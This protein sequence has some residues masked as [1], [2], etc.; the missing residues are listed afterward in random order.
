MVRYAPHQTTP[1]D[2]QGHDHH[3][4]PKKSL[5]FPRPRLEA[6]VSSRVFSTN[7]A[8]PGPAAG[9]AA[10]RG[11]SRRG[12][13]KAPRTCGLAEGIR[14]KRR[15]EGWDPEEWWHGWNYVKVMTGW[16]FG[17]FFIFPYIEGLKP[18]TRWQ[19]F[20]WN[21]WTVLG[22]IDEVYSELVGN[23][24]VWKLDMMSGS[25][26]IVA[27]I[28]NEDLERFHWSIKSIKVVCRVDEWREVEPSWW[29]E[30]IYSPHK[31]MWSFASASHRSVC[32]KFYIGTE[33]YRCKL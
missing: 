20:W 6:P 29:N 9:P 4:Q 25:C 14:R 32:I 26:R 30:G 2:H 15:V 3:D 28:Q 33:W 7:R 10:E 24:N 18:S 5:R 27:T 11:A 21:G 1:H 22:E 23:Q 13:W 17:T 16:W 12:R 8:T 19:V 31:M